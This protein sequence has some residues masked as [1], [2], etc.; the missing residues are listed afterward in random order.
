MFDTRV[1]GKKIMTLRKEKNLTQMNLADAIGVSFQA[2]SNW[3]RGNSMP[4][5]SK[6]PELASYLETTVDELLGPSN[7]T[8]I[9]THI[10]EGK[11]Q[12]VIHSVEDIRSV[13]PL[14]EPEKV[15]ELVDHHMKELSELSD[16]APFVSSEYLDQIIE[17]TNVLDSDMDW[18]SIAA[19]LPI[20]TLEKISE[21][22]IAHKAYDKLHEIVAYLSSDYLDE[23]VSNHMNEDIGISRYY[24]FLSNG[25]NEHIADN[26]ITDERYRELSD[27]APFLSE[28]YI[29]ALFDI[30]GFDIDGLLPF[31]SVNKIRHLAEKS[32]KKQ[33]HKQLVRLAPFLGHDLD[34]ILLQSDVQIDLKPFYPFLQ[35]K[36]IHKIA[37]RII[38]GKANKS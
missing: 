25:M 19:F 23:F 36:T 37:D 2:V 20:S 16:I 3:E 12:E 8:T 1:V 13:A 10:I 33:D 14:L 17:K 31:A 11:S 15:D 4:D 38:K 22:L 32:L 30:E 5:I 21:I 28:T 24:P 6:L 27:I 29:D 26:L 7:E 35:M 9:V 34:L 18:M